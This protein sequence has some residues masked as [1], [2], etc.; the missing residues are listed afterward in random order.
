M[1]VLPQKVPRLGHGLL[2]LRINL[3]SFS[4]FIS[5]RRRKQKDT[6]VVFFLFIPLAPH[7]L[8]SKLFKKIYHMTY[9]VVGEIGN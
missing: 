4:C 1:E 3:I 5:L 8:G 9:S 2:L 6:K 7:Y